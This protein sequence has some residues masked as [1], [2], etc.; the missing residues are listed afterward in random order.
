MRRLANPAP[1]PDPLPCVC[2]GG[3]MLE[4]ET[5]RVQLGKVIDGGY[6]VTSGRYV[7]PCCGR[8]SG[9][10]CVEYG[11]DKAVQDWNLKH[12]RVVITC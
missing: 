12:G 8:S 6:S 4:Q 7:C 5:K 11:W 10:R 9:W 2:G 1:A 3:I